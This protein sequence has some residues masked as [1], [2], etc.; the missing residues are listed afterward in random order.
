MTSETLHTCSYSCTRPACVLAQRNELR[1]KL[2]DSQDAANKFANSQQADE[3]LMWQALEALQAVVGYQEPEHYVE[4]EVAL[5]KA[6][7][8]ITVLRERLEEPQ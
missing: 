1:A 3:A 4:R 6:R 8:S 2:E 7:A 5:R